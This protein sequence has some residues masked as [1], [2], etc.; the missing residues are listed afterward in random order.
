MYEIIQGNS[1]SEIKLGLIGER[2]VG[3][4]S[5]LY[6]YFGLKFKNNLLNKFWPKTMETKFNSTNNQDIQLIISDTYG[7]EIFY[8]FTINTIK[9]LKGI[10]IVF[11]VTSRE[12]FD[13]IPEWLESVKEECSDPF[14]V[15]FGNKSD[16]NEKREVSIEE[17][18]KF[19]KEKKLKYFEVSA[20]S[21][22]GIDEGINYIAN[23]IYEKYLD[24][25]F[26]IKPKIKKGNKNK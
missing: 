16:L 25:Y 3:K 7:A 14:I 2:K 18:N 15:L 13:K 21:K 19:A 24:E 9:D 6:S 17:I 10:I 23:L 8:Y 12:T 4:T 20:H 5:I 22:K 11:D 26:I 1:I